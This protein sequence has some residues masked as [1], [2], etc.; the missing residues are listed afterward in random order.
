VNH[1]G[2]KLE[3]SFVFDPVA[4]T[5]RQSVQFTDSSS[6]QPTSWHWDFDDGTSSSL[7]NPTHA[8]AAAGSYNVSL[9]ASNITSNDSIA[10]EVEVSPPGIHRAASPALAD[11]K[12]AI[13]SAEPGDNVIV[14]EGWATWS[15][16]LLITK[17]IILKGA[18][19]GKTTIVSSYSAPNTYADISNFLV[20]YIPVSPES[21]DPFRITGFTFDFGDSCLG[22]VLGNPGMQPIDK[23][24][25]DHLELKN[26]KGRIFLIVGAVYGVAD[27]NSIDGQYVCCYADNE[28]TWEYFTF[29]NGT[30]DNFYFEDNSFSISDTAF[31]GGAGGR[32]CVR[33]NTFT[34]SNPSSGLFPWFDMHGNQGPGAN[35]SNMGAEVYGNILNA[36]SSSV[37]LFDHRGGKAIIYENTINTFGSTGAQVREEYND[38][39]NPPVTT[40]DGQPQHVSDSYYWNNWKN[41]A[42]RIEVYV[43]D[44]VNYGGST[45]LVPQENRDFWQEDPSF[46]GSSGVGFGLKTNRPITCT[47]GVGYW[48]TDEKVLYRCTE[49]NVWTTYYTP[50]VYP[51]PLRTFFSD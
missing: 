28:T 15:S 7:Q 12:A 42:V 16:P 13:S 38:S 4:P 37:D 19:L 24:R 26:S 29:A 21:N 5:E 18:G 48:A 27:N 33:N 25:I 35:L 31:F 36:S 22:I 6:G 32:Y 17:G 43:T 20:Q 40:S 49:T 47:V 30:A 3:A 23:I 51:H 41:G 14:P 45:G 50:Y 39:L 2:V 9:T 1:P 11:V 44:T 46:D 8:F 10:R 34:F